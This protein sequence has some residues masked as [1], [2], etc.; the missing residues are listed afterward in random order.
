MELIKVAHISGSLTNFLP[1]QLVNLLTHQTTCNI[2]APDPFN[3]IV[4]QT[5]PMH[6]KTLLLGLLLPVIA[7]S[8]TSF[9]Y[10]DGR[11]SPSCTNCILLLKEA[12]KEV[13]F[14]IDIQPNGDIYFSMS[15]KEW[16]NKLFTD[17]RDGVG[18]D[19]VSKDQYDCRGRQSFTYGVTK[20]FTLPP[21]YLAEL[22]KNLKDLG[23]GHLAVKVGQ[24]PQ[25]LSKKELEGNLLFIRGGLVCQSK[26]F[27]DLPRI[28]WTLLPMGLYTDTVVNAEPVTDTAS[29]TS[30]F[31]IKK[32]QFNI[33]F[34][35]NKSEYNAAD[36]KPLYDSLK[37]KD[38][39]ISSINIRAYSSVEGT[40]QANNLLQQQRAQSIV[41]ALQQFQTPAI[42]NNIT[43][44]ENWIGFYNDIAQS[45]YKDMSSLSK[46][47]VK[48]RLLD[49][50]L[51]EQL[52]PYLSNHRK[53]LIT[54]YLN[55]KTGF[56]RTKTDSLLQQFKKAIVQKKAGVASILQDAIFQRV[57]DGLLP[58]TFIDKLEVPR[59]KIFSNLMNNQVTY[60]LLLD[61]TDEAEALEDLK[62]IATY[63][64]DN[65]RVKYNICAL[66]FRLWEYQP[67]YTDPA[68]L[69]K[70]I[71]DLP[72]AGI[73]PTLVKRML[74]NYNIV[75]CSVYNSQYKYAEKDSALQYI[76][77]NYAGLP[78]NDEDRLALAQYLSWYSQKG[79][80]EE[81]LT[82]RIHDIDVSEN[83]LF[84]YLNLKLFTPYSFF[85][86]PVKKAALNAISI[87]KARFCR[88]F[89]SRDKG[90]SSFQLLDDLSLHSIYCENCR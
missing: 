65:A 9:P 43:T 48:T 82:K 23:E 19:L 81:L 72:K 2:W 87:N 31:Y 57:A 33:P 11:Q 56:E 18:V 26:N 90:G 21:V 63:S 62:D 70:Y 45:P 22:R 36:I 85:E 47:Q 16:F 74:I 52:E 37:L 39:S 41:K 75:M 84:Y 28:Q 58:E 10:A 44:G 12:P 27:A 32:L 68:V 46:P 50:V 51:L 24:V 38:Y 35:K 66:T 13:Q 25:S 20:G 14:G 89:N 71:R 5:P 3:W 1:R 73:D 61:I 60:K 55:K 7:I 42:K 67:G 17:L 59:E 64:S 78:L 88:F 83:L 80:A 8:Q 49:K 34:S 29:A 79:W 4:M 53:A 30:P 54:I 76:H 6:L 40:E 69:L 86:A 77:E 15:N